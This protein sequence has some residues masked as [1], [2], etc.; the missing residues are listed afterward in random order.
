[1]Y[2]F[3]FKFSLTFID[4]KLKVFLFF[5]NFRR[6]ENVYY[7]SS[8]KFTRLSFLEGILLN[9]GNFIFILFKS[10]SLGKKFSFSFSIYILFLSRM[11]RID[12]FSFSCFSFFFGEIL[13]VDCLFDFFSLWDRG[14]CSYSTSGCFG[15]DWS[16]FSF[17]TYY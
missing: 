3:T 14:R 12:A 9:I 4:L 7:P 15:I 2:F 16:T 1:M 10:S 11:F 6:I 8:T 5:R 13:S 17:Y